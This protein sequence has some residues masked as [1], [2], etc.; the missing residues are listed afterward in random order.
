MSEIVNLI[1]DAQRAAFE[2]RFAD[3]A[4]H[5]SAALDRLPTCLIGLRVLA[6]AQLELDDDA[7]LATF[8]TCADYDPED[9]LAHVGQAIWYQQRNRNDA[10][11]GEWVRAWELDPHN[12]SIR[13]A[14]VKLTGEL[15]ESVFADAVSLLR[16]GHEDEAA[17]TLRRL[18]GEREEAAVA[19]SLIG[20][21][22]SAG[23]QRDAFELA[24]N[25]LA[26]HPR[27]VKAALY[28]AALEDRAG[29]TLRSREVIARA[30]QV[31]PGLTLFEEVVRQVGLQP[32]LDLHRA[33]RTPLTVGR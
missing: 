18:R 30:E 7:A 24:I 2:H 12:Q 3:A 4:T 13:R 15:P 6:W 11:I 1:A 32:A 10:A 33:S 8:Q 14:L 5:A 31:D 19:L 28:V 23:A 17:E 9:A 20:A 26:S 25:V 29:R 21:L 16:R 27:S 22:W